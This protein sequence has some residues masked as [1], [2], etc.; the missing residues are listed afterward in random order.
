[1]ILRRKERHTLHI[2]ASH[3]VSVDRHVRLCSLNNMYRV[4]VRR[5]KMC[6]SN[7]S[8]NTQ[9]MN[10]LSI[11]GQ[12]STFSTLIGTQLIMYDVHIDSLI[13]WFI[14]MLTSIYTSLIT[15]NSIPFLSHP[16]KSTLSVT[17]TAF[18]SLSLN[19]QPDPHGVTNSSPTSSNSTLRWRTLSTT[20]SG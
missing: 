9:M 2:T 13:H 4:V 18:N 19:L 17:S 20:T 16:E 8:F 11:Y 5:K 1:M 15:R 14:E 7:S 3:T 6:I 12:I 10:V